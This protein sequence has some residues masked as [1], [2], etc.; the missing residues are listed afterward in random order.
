MTEGD[1]GAETGSSNQV[2]LGLSLSHVQRVN[3]ILVMVEIHWRVLSSGEV[4]FDLSL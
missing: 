1:G 3:F 2:T 4:W